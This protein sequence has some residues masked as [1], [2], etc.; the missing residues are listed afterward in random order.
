MKKENIEYSPT[1]KTNYD[2]DY[3]CNTHGEYTGQ[4]GQCPQCAE[5]KP[6][7]EP[8]SIYATDAQKRE[9]LE[10]L[11]MEHKLNCNQAIHADCEAFQK[12]KSEWNKLQK[13]KWADYAF[14]ECAYCQQH[15][16]VFADTYEFNLHFMDCPSCKK[17][18]MSGF[19][20]GQFVWRK[21]EGVL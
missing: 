15:M 8:W 7:F 4:S 20:E 3:K 12:L 14:D 11:M 5:S 1:H 19:I 10:R 16:G 21:T 13:G 9:W 6:P 18:N 17:R 2:M